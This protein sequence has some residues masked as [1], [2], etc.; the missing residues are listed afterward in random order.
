MASMGMD[1][2]YIILKNIKSRF[3]EGSKMK[4][5]TTIKKVLWFTLSITG[6][7]IIQSCVVYRPDTTKLVSV[8]D[9]V[10]MSKD[11]LYSKDIIE[12]INQ[13]HTAYNLKADQLVKLHE[14]GVQDSVIN[15]MEET[16]MDLVQQNSRYAVSS[17][18]WL[19]DG[20]SY[21]GF[22]WGAPYYGLYGWGLGPTVVYNM[23]RGFRG[24]YHRSAGF[25]GG[26][27][28]HGGIRR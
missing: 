19:Y 12:E 5:L 7:T 26:G 4:N 16:K 27:Y 15:F 14:E 6:V 8:P 9:V 25:H 23:N 10:Q 11:G 24:G 28:R 1:I 18:W 21:G 20:F 2:A 17:N 22:G 3:E 13:S